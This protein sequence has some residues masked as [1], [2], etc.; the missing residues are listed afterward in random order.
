MVSGHL[1]Y[2]PNVPPS[3][4]VAAGE[5]EGDPAPAGA[6]PPRGGPNGRRLIMP[7][8]DY[9]LEDHNYTRST[10]LTP[11]KSVYVVYVVYRSIRSILMEDSLVPREE[12]DEQREHPGLKRPAA[13]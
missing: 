2:D 13:E 11:I 4:G 10:Y 6:P 9:V 12:E 7:L 8:S 1:E 3:A 5:T